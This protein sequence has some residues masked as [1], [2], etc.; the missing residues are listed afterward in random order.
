MK[1]FILANDC[2]TAVC[3]VVGSILRGLAETTPVAS[4]DFFHFLGRLLNFFRRISWNFSFIRFDTV[5]LYVEKILKIFEGEFKII[6][7]HFLVNATV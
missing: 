6:L 5:N 3:A 4:T 2:K 7:T 1:I